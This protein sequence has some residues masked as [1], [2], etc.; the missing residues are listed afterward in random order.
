MSNSTK[1]EKLKSA[2]EY[3]K[4]NP[5]TLV[6]DLVRLHKTNRRDFSVYLKAHSLPRADGRTIG[7][8]SPRQQAIKDAY[9]AA[10]KANETPLWAKRYAKEKFGCDIGTGD[11]RYYAMK[12]GLPDLQEGTSPKTE[13]PHKISL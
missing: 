13:S 12:N 11:F 2:Y 7:S 5:H 3:W 4:K 10:A 8:G 1:E 9:E 6:E